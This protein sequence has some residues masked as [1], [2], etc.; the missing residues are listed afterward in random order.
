ML[1]R[2]KKACPQ[3]CSQFVFSWINRY[4]YLE[5]TDSRGGKVRYDMKV[6]S[7]KWP[8]VSY[9]RVSVTPGFDIVFLLLSRSVALG[10]RV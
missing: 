2:T 10:K 6:G 4:D 8:K 1:G 9:K 3:T 5:F 7:E